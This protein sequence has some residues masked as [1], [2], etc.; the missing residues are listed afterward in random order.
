MSDHRNFTGGRAPRSPS[1]A[2][3][4]I[5]AVSAIALFGGA[6]LMLLALAVA[7]IVRTVAGLV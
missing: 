7:W 1:H 3:D 2:P 4:E 5:S 6:A